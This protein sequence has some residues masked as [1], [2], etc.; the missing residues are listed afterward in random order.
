MASSSPSPSSPIL[1][2]EEILTQ[3]QDLQLDPNRPLIISDAD[4]VL[5][6]FME[7]LE[8]FLERQGL[9]IDLTKFAISGN[10]RSRETDELVEVPNL[11]EDFFTTETLHLSPTQGAAKSLAAL[12]P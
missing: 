4:E 11:V 1:P 9:W 10:I 8:H 7:R 3:L 6:R 12:A 2:S 5:L